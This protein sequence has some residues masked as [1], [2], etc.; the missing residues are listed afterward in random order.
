MAALPLIVE[1]GASGFLL[2]GL[3]DLRVAV[4][5]FMDGPHA[6]LDASILPRRLLALFFNQQS[7][8]IGFLCGTLDLPP[9][10]LDHLECLPEM[11]LNLVVFP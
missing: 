4:E 1:L 11:A 10:D 7:G 9:C 5:D 2:M 3:A 6:V 8:R